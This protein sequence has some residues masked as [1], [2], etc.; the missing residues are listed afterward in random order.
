MSALGPLPKS[1]VMTLMLSV[2]D[3]TVQVIRL[4]GLYQYIRNLPSMAGFFDSLDATSHG[5]GGTSLDNFRDDLSFEKVSTAAWSIR[6]CAEEAAR[7]Y[8]LRHSK[9]FS[10]KILWAGDSS[11]IT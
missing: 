1:D 7:I 9:N 2:D 6:S 8:T 3:D 10:G 4:T 11:I 5:L